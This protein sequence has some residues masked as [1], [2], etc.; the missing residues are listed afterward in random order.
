VYA[1]IHAKPLWAGFRTY[2]LDYL[3]SSIGTRVATE[4]DLKVYFNINDIPDAEQ[5]H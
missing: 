3:K 5:Q 2:P 4:K 1:E